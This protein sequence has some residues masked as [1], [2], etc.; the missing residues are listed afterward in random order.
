MKNRFI[1]FRRGEVFYSEDTVTSK[2]QSLHT[3]IESE[4]LTLL[5]AKNE[6]FRQP[7]LNLQI[8]RAYLSASDPQ[9]VQR[10]WQNVMDEICTH[11][12]EQTKT[13]YVRFMKSE[14]FDGLRRKKLLET[15]ADDFLIV[16]K[17]GKVSVD[18]Y[19]KRLH[20]L[21]LSFGWL[22]VP[23]LA[24]A[25]WPKPNFKPKRGITLD[26]HQRILAV[27]LNSERNLYYQLLW[28]I[29]ASQ[30]DAASL[31]AENIDW[32]DGTITY[33]RK[34]TG[35][36]AQLSISSTLAA[37][38]N[39]LPTKGPLF[40]KIFGLKDKDRA[41]E[42]RRRCRILKI[43]GISLHSYRY[44]WAERARSIGYP[45]R[46]AQEA[47][48]HNSKAVHRAY[49]KRAS[50]KI[51]SLEEYEEKARKSLDA[52]ADHL[53]A[54]DSVAGVLRQDG[55]RLRILNT[56]WTSAA[57]VTQSCLGILWAN[58]EPSVESVTKARDWG[59]LLHAR[60]LAWA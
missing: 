37:I 7:S 43:E 29:G 9:M 21:A 56:R 53:T 28:E 1:L 48:G 49:A 44:A 25:F 11:G 18:H 58:G 54:V 4:A 36:R 32:R 50:V 60:M 46:F 42:F 8:A 38:L 34:K 57:T 23:V 3:K 24:P 47:L 16:L 22:P 27:E 14:A 45:E 55:M 33:F 40:P 52:A 39:Q 30:T 51:P 17:D 31:L 35:T 2:Q 12:K 6:S 13:R 20:N 15:T 19:L 10:T 5:N 59:Q 41:A 26:E